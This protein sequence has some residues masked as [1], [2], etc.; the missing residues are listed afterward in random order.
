M[1]KC[2]IAAL[3]LLLSTGLCFGQAPRA[4]L[5]A[6]HGSDV[7]VGAIATFPDFE[8]FGTFRLYG[9]EVA[10]TRNLSTRWAGIASGAAVF[11]STFDV[12]QFSG[13][14]GVKFN[15]LTGGFRPYAT[16]QI[17]YAYQSSN[18]MYAAS[19]HPVLRPHTTD[20]EDGLTYRLGFGADLQLSRR[21]YWR[22]AQ[23][24][25]QPLPWGRHTPFYS[26]F[27]SG[28]GYRFF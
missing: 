8:Q 20:T 7:Y 1:K 4:A 3:L 21:V 11:G 16:T 5:N 15:F 17:G 14:A 10:Y 27:S 24:D 6:P 2:S 19:H 18:G 12:T 22:V 25:I 26:N 9:G 13:T 28:I 23:W